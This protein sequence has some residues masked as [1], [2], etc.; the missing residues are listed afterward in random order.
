MHDLQVLGLPAPA[1][2]S[3]SSTTPPPAPES[4][5]RMGTLQGERSRVPPPTPRGCADLSPGALDLHSFEFTTDL[6]RDQRES[7]PSLFKLEVVDRNP[8]DSGGGHAGKGRRRR[9][10]RSW[11]L[12]PPWSWARS[13][14]FAALTHACARGR[15]R[16]QPAQGDTAKASLSTG[17]CLALV[18]IF[19]LVRRHLGCLAFSCLRERRLCPESASVAGVAASPIGGAVNKQPSHHSPTTNP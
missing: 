11:P 19:G 7:G 1:R 12:R 4:P 16:V 18:T 13:A 3:P 17:G 15:A 6:G 5:G 8:A 10:D 9:K 2:P 14:G